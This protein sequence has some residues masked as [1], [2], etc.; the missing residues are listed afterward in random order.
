MINFTTS[1]A[2]VDATLNLQVARL[3]SE[4][5]GKFY[6]ILL[7]ED[8]TVIRQVNLKTVKEFPRSV[9]A[10]K[11]SNAFEQLQDSMKRLL[12]HPQT[13]DAWKAVYWTIKGEV[14]KINQE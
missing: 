9:I 4:S 6:E 14:A 13:S 12:V 5:Q 7:Y 3:S 10:K 11:L 8:G 1:I 2:I